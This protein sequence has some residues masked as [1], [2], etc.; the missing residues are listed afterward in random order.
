MPP[1]AD[2]FKDRSEAASPAVS[3][4][5]PPQAIAAP[6]EHAGD[7][8]ILPPPM[9]AANRPR[10]QVIDIATAAASMASVPVLDIV[11]RRMF[12]D[13]LRGVRPREIRVVYQCGRPLRVDEVDSILREVA[14]QDRERRIA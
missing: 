9:E 7:Y 11:K 10:P 2:V 1:N 3:T 13:W 4:K 5:K 8:P 14:K 12:R 6:S